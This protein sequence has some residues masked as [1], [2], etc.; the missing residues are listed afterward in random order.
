[1]KTHFL[2]FLLLI[3]FCTFSCSRGNEEET[4]P[5]TPLSEQQLE[6]EIYDSLVV[7]YLGNLVLMDISPDKNVFLLMEQNSNEILIT[8]AEG[9]IL[10][11]YSRS[12]EGPDAYGND[13]SG[14]AT[15][16]SNTEY[17]IPTTRNVV[18]YDLDGN[19]IR[20]IEPD[21]QGMANLIVSA[22]KSVI[23][24]GNNLYFKIEGRSHGEDDLNKKNSLEK[25]NFETG[26]FIPIVPF[27][28]TSKFMN[29]EIE[30]APFDYFPIY[31]VT[32][33]SL[34][35]MF[36]NEP[37]LFSYS[38]DNLDSPAY[39]K[40]IPFKEFIE[41]KTD[42]STDN[43]GFNLRDFLLGSVN[44]VVTL[45]DGSF[46]LFYTSGLT[47]EQAAEVISEAG[48]DFNKIF[49]LAEK[50]NDTGYVL[51]DGVSTSNLI[52]RID[53]LSNIAKV[54]NKD[55]IWFNLNFSEAENDYSVIYKTRIVEK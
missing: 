29:E 52:G 37:K 3:A 40:K 16:I 20:K 2:L 49:S 39:Y 21:F 27:P 30:F 44:D 32:Q 18:Q 1:M 55:E 35:F 51:F 4:K 5:S 26:E 6:F 10:H 17:L 53:L 50:Y 8:D 48:T 12:G 24:R 23:K 11:Q 7:D 42:N 31:E 9:S 41:R 54:V 36:R 47:D 22:S 28:K 38:L 13:K 34:F 33:D 43:G 45:E 25:V 19:L 15:F 14:K 46:L